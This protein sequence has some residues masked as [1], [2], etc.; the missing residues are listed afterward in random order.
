MNQDPP[1]GIEVFR[2]LTLLTPTYPRVNQISSCLD[3]KDARAYKLAL[4]P[5]LLCRCKCTL[6]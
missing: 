6:Y 5:S 4:G 1:S 3:I 2:A